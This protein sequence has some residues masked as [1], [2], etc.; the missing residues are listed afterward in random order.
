MRFPPSLII[1]QQ[2]KQARRAREKTN[3]ERVI[4]FNKISPPLST[5]G[6]P[7]SGFLSGGVGVNAGDLP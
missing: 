4:C 1:G 2:P 7:A 5:D 3:K 6:N